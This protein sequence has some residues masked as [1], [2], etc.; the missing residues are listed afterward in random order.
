M[1]PAKTH[2]SIKWNNVSQDKTNGKI[3]GYIIRITGA[4]GAL[5]SKESTSMQEFRANGLN[6]YNN[7]SLYVQAYTSKGEGPESPRFD[8]E[9]LDEGIQICMCIQ[10][11]D[12]QV[13]VLLSLVHRWAAEWESCFYNPGQNYALL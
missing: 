13:R 8:F 6:A 7:Y 3:L 5:F 1:V 12:S 9:T 10:M 2:A 4:N 11:F